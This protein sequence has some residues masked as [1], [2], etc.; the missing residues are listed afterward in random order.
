MLLQTLREQI[1]QIGLRMV[2]DGLAHGAQG[3]ISALDV[4][5]GLIAITPSAYPY[6]LRK[7]E[8]ICVIDLQRNLVE[9]KWKPTSEIALH[10][11]FYQK[12]KDVCAVVHSHAPN[13]TVFG[14]INE[15][16][17]AVLTEAAFYLTGSVPVAPYACPGSDEVAEVTYAAIGESGSAAVMAH[18]G[19][20]TVG[21]NLEHAYETTL[22]AEM[23]ARIV[24]MARSM[25]AKEI[26]LDP[27]EGAIFRIIR[28]Y[29]L[30]TR[31][32]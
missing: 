20:L 18:H 28:E 27:V 19:L 4:E 10:T 6:Y 3:N 31:S 2:E 29:G 25:G 13:S 21:D 11:I 17:P 26:P 30:A 5:T 1:V 32:R 14:V 15:Q 8:D 24:I 7:A 12:R 22:A 16:I 23:T 9:G